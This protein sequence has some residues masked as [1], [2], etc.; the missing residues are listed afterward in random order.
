MT[1]S[2][3]LSQMF[4]QRK[5]T[6][7]KNSVASSTPSSDAIRRL[8]INPSG[9]LG[10]FYDATI[11]QIL[12]DKVLQ[13]GNTPINTIPLEKPPLCRLMDIDTF[14]IQALFLEIRIHDELWLDVILNNLTELGMHSLVNCSLP[15]NK[16]T[17]FLYY[18]YTSQRRLI[19]SAPT[20]VSQY[21]PKEIP[22]ID[23][24]H[25]ISEIIVGIQA[26]VVLELPS[27]NETSADKLLKRICDRLIKNKFE[28]KIDEQNCLSR[29]KVIQVF[30]NILDLMETNDLARICELI[31]R[32]KPHIRRQ[33]PLEYSLHDIQWFYPNVSTRKREF[34]LLKPS[35][36][37][38]IKECL[39]YLSSETK[40]LAKKNTQTTNQPDIE[41]IRKLVANVRAGI[42]SH[43]EGTAI[44]KKIS[45]DLFQDEANL[46]PNR[47][48]IFSENKN[49][50]NDL[51]QKDSEDATISNKQLNNI[52]RPTT[53]L[54]LQI[55]PNKNHVSAL[56]EGST[57]EQKQTNAHRTS[58]ISEKTDESL[59]NTMEISTNQSQVAPN[60]QHPARN[61]VR[62]EI[63][64][65][66]IHH[67]Q[68]NSIE[69]KD[70]RLKS[71][72]L[73]TEKDIPTSNEELITEQKQTNVFN[74]SSITEKSD[75]SMKNMIRIPTTRSQTFSSDEKLTSNLETGDARH[76]NIHDKQSNNT[77]KKE[78]RLKS[79][80]LTKEKD[81]SAP[82]KELKKEPKQTS[83][84]NTLP[85]RIPEAA[86]SQKE[87][88]NNNA[89]SSSSPTKH[90]ADDVP[91]LSTSNFINILLLGESGVGKSTFIN[92]FVN[93]LQF[94]TFE[95]ACSSKPVV[96]MPVSFLI[97]VGDQFEEQTVKFGDDD[98]NEDHNHPG[99]SVTQHCRSYVFKMNEEMNLRIIDTPGIGDSRGIHQ[100][101]LNMQNILLFIN[102]LSHLNAICI[103]LKPN[104]SRLN[105]ILRSYFNRLL[106]FFGENACHNIVFCF[107][108]TRATFYAPGDT[109]PL[110]KKMI[111]NVP[112]KH[113]PFNKANTFSFDNESFRYLV[114][115]Q[116]G[117]KFDKYQEEEYRSSW[118]VSVT[119]SNRLF[120][121]VS[122][123]LTSFIDIEWHS[124][125]HLQ[126][127]VNE[128][129]RPTLEAMRNILRNIAL[130]D[131]KKSKA[132]I[133]LKTVAVSQS[134]SIC[135]ECKRS[136]KE[137]N[138][139]WI[140]P[141][142]LHLVPEMS[143]KCKCGHTKHINVNYKLEYETWHDVNQPSIMEMKSNFNKLKEVILDLG[144][145][146]SGQ[147]S[148]ARWFVRRLTQTLLLNG[149]HSNDYGPLRIPILIRIGQAL[150]I[151]DGLDEVPVSDQRSEII[152][153]VENFVETYV[154]TPKGVSVFDN[155][156]LSKLLDDPSRSEGNQL[157]VTSCIVG[158]HAATLAGQFSH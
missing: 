42:W 70:T 47:S 59:R 52:D 75:E 119:E 121:Y 10:S 99:Q 112:D 44:L 37:N 127:K 139:M 49:Y 45:D 134:S 72:G 92:A 60:D 41:R 130:L 154:Q 104:E 87:Q 98:S 140:L 40:R 19:V 66:I 77:E 56:N 76:L 62:N 35:F 152:N 146:S 26:F 147:T 51:E 57:N 69:I 137:F 109:A 113:I 107:T 4:R 142:D 5:G 43:E 17:R 39:L 36:Q 100:D 108:N 53:P 28:L 148:F 83:L 131:E 141:D 2:S 106:H 93:Y 110:L 12:L 89:D 3:S 118:K 88:S 126:L 9:I 54:K 132:Q 63:K 155:V 74:T 61:F 85:S 86:Q 48:Q 101:D 34:T 22:A 25:I 123:E 150:I 124:S 151:L 153:I 14:D 16:K 79:A 68:S 117:I 80:G 6:S 102:N 95:R 11:D 97:T 13:L 46:P 125:E 120:K 31:T 67:N 138:G 111:N 8:A 129:I 115:V 133:K 136:P 135:S 116:H 38:K 73:P 55:S 15:N 29:I 94:D 65:S 71:A 114:A 157:I 145:S 24:T 103:L 128:I 158:Y 81:G 84:S 27:S 58:S 7:P 78:T 33:L 50:S 143:S 91:S 82:N 122:E 105:I 96:L 23:A 64:Y 18:R 156:Y 32:K 90:R 144:D 1:D 30:S 149:Q 20:V 21:I